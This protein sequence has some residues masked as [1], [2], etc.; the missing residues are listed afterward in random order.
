LGITKPHHR[1]FACS[2]VRAGFDHDFYN[3]DFTWAL[4]KVY[5]LTII[6]RNLAE[7]IADLPASYAILRGVSKKTR[8]LISS[9]RTV[10]ESNALPHSSNTV[11][12]PRNVYRKG[13]KDQY[14]YIDDEVPLQRYSPPI[15]GIVM[16]T[17]IDVDRLEQQ[18]EDISGHGHMNV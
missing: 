9:R 16:R 5:L 12:A 15:N 8:T 7:V 17:S 18:T 4:D 13:S 10:Q 6:E 3:P 1:V 14:Q 2:I 11:S